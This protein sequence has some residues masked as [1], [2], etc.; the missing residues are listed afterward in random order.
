MG[1]AAQ[2]I[3]YG[4]KIKSQAGRS[5]NTTCDV[6]NYGRDAEGSAGGSTRTVH[7]DVLRTTAYDRN[8]MFHAIQLHNIGHIFSAIDRVGITVKI[9]ETEI[10]A[11]NKN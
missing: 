3:R 9:G 8:A 7:S 5:D 10:R 11:G 6:E 2:C 4:Q 1:L